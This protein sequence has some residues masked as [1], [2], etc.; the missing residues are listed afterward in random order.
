[1]FGSKFRQGGVPLLHKI[2][3]SKLD[4][5]HPKKENKVKDGQRQEQLKTKQCTII[6][7]NK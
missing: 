1:M 3:M 7:V 6:F 2:W 4:S 5:Y